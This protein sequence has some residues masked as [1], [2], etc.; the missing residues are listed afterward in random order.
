MA[1][2]IKRRSRRVWSAMRLVCPVSSPSIGLLRSIEPR[3]HRYSPRLVCRLTDNCSLSVRESNS[4]AL[5]SSDP[6]IAR[7]PATWLA[8]GWRRRRCCSSRVPRS[9]PR[10]TRRSTE[11]CASCRWPRTTVTGRP[12]ARASGF[13]H[14]SGRRCGKASYRAHVLHGDLRDPG[15]PQRPSGLAS[16]GIASGFVLSGLWPPRNRCRR[17][18]DRRP[19]CG[20]TAR[21]TRVDR[22]TPRRES[23]HRLKTFPHGPP[24]VAP[25]CKSGRRSALPAVP[26]SRIYTTVGTRTK[27]PTAGR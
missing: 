7:L 27:S 8:T 13:S 4:P 10:S 24:N 26:V 19:T 9:R 6:R 21:S 15:V 3:D 1:S 2:T 5:A 18:G 22:R 12:G 11:S 25:V 20:R 23:R 14:D 17:V 16:Q